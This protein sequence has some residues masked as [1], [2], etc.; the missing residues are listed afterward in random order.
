MFI[1]VNLLRSSGN[2]SAMHTKYAVDENASLVTMVPR[3]MLNK[4]PNASSNISC[5]IF[6]KRNKC[7]SPT[8]PHDENNHFQR[9][10]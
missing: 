10:C 2:Y 4:I 7:E 1:M 6:Q 9:E 3:H 5:L 8:S